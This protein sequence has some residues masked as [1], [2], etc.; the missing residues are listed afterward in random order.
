MGL[1]IKDVAKRAGVSIATVSRVINNKGL[2][3]PET[4]QKVLSAIDELHYAPNAIAQSLKNRKSKLIG[5]LASDLSVS[6]FV[7]I[8]QILERELMKAGYQII[9][10]NTYDSPETEAQLIGR[11]TQGHTDIL[12]VNPTGG[13]DELLAKVQAS[14]VHLLGY[15]RYPGNRQ[16]PSVY[17]DKRQGIYMILSHLY[18]LGHRRM[19]FLSGPERLSTNQDRCAGIRQFLAD[20]DLAE[21]SVVICQ[22]EFTEFFAQQVAEE[23]QRGPNPPTAYITGSVSLATGIVKYCERRGV[24]IP[25]DLS[26]ASFG[27]FRDYT[28]IKPSLLH[29]DDE[30]VAVARQLLRWIRALERTEGPAGESFA[31]VVIPPR[32]ICG[33]SCAPPRR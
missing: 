28:I 12:L 26:I 10:A 18:S 17:V 33:D 20:Y 29:I 15:D 11:M 25:E 7:G 19:C 31:D 22:S 9:L 6:F 24:S 14:G 8:L 21:D 16:F 27:T 5:M 23:Q 32:L 2:V 1:T 3:I 30:Y 13:N 4:E